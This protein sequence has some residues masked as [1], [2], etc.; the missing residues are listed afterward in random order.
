MCWKASFRKRG[1]SDFQAKEMQRPVKTWG[2]PALRE[3]YF[4]EGAR[5][6]KA[7]YKHIGRKE[8]N[9]GVSSLKL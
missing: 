5:L 4:S 3:L 6:S 9:L 2:L 8:L 1:D 7:T